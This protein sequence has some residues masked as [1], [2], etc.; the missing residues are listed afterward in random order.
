MKKKQSPSLAST[1]IRSARGSKVMAYLEKSPKVCS[2]KI[3]NPTQAS[4][5]SLR[6]AKISSKQERKDES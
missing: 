2:K 6:A 4:L 3:S 1:H 5:S